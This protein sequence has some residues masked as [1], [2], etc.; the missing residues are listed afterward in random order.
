MSSEVILVFE[1]AFLTLA[2]LF[3]GM[4][5]THALLINAPKDG[6]NKFGIKSNLRMEISLEPYGKTYSYLSL[7]DIAN[8]AI[9]SNGGSDFFNSLEETYIVFS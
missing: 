1:G 5:A 8:S 2:R 7:E 3:S 4:Q 9:I 6:G